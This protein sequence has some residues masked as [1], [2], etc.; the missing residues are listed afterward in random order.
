[1]AMRQQSKP[2][3]PAGDA[4]DLTRLLETEARLEE[5]LRQA[6]EEAARLIA[7][8]QQAARAREEALGAE[9]AA[10]VQQLDATIEAERRRQEREIAADARRRAE[11][12]D[13]VSP[14]RVEELTRDIVG[15]IIGEGSGR[16]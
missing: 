11:G 8:A 12:F 13:Q 9:L 14:E 16:A 1:M 4:G 10:A 7:E 3:S 15:R 2:S 6:R 5:M